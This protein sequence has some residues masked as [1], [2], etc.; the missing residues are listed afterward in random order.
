MTSYFRFNDKLPKEDEFVN[1]VAVLATDPVIKTFRDGD[2]KIHRKF[3]FYIVQDESAAI[4]VT[5]V[6]NSQMFELKLMKLVVKEGT[7]IVMN[8]LIVANADPLQ[9]ELIADDELCILAVRPNKYQIDRFLEV[10][11]IF[12]NSDFL[13]YTV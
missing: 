1:V 10:R 5:Y 11:K 9:F 4:P 3:T 7:I 8:N 6:S 13:K 12:C 2:D